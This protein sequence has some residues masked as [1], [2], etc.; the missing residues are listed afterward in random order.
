MG[1]PALAAGWGL[2]GFGVWSLLAAG[3]HRDALIARDGH[4]RAVVVPSLEV[5]EL[6]ARLSDE[7]GVDAV[8]IALKEAQP[9]GQLVAVAAH[10]DARSLLGQ[11]LAPD[12]DLTA[13]VAL[14]GQCESRG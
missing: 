1:W 12:G 10:G 7:P 11:A 6:A 4:E 5:S 9:L 8:V 13:R 2:A 3:Q 14:A